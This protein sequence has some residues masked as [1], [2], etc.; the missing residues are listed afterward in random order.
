MLQVSWKE[1]KCT[2]DS[3]DNISNSDQVN[4][5]QPSTDEA[6]FAI[7]SRVYVHKS[8]I[9]HYEPRTLNF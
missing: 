5:I 6:A 3:V 9:S 1:K 4:H 8:Q 7:N 2:V